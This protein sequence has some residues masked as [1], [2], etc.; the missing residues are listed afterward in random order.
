[1][2][3]ATALVLAQLHVLSLADAL[4]LAQANQP[5]MHQAKAS[6]AVGRA[7]A[8]QARAPLLPQLTGTATYQRSTGNYASSPGAVPASVAKSV[9]NSGATFNNF[10]FGLTLSQLVWDF[11]VAWENWRSALAKVESLASVEKDTWRQQAALVRSSF[12]AAQASRALV[13]VGRA[14][15]SA[16]AQHLQQ[17]EGFVRVGTQPE[18]ALY[19]ARA[20]L[21]NARYQLTN[22]ES[23]YGI[24]LAQLQQ[25]MGVDGPVDFDVSNENQP[26]IAG[27]DQPADELLAIAIKAR[28]DLASLDQQIRAQTLAV[29]AQWAAFAPSIGVSTGV[30][31]KGTDI[32]N[33]A[34]NWNFT[35]NLN[36]S[37][38]NGMLA[39]AQLKQQ[40]ANLI[41]LR[42]Q[43][44]AQKQQVRLDVA[45]ALLGI[46]AS[47]DG[48]VSA[49][50]AVSNSSQQ[51]RLAE[52]RFAAGV[53][54]I[55]ELSDA[56]LA[57]TTAGAQKVQAEFNLAAARVGLLKALG[58]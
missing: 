53:G 42:A 15:V 33:T 18:I 6:I 11:G 46:R 41:V 16:Q 57:A 47:R 44:D 29:R 50:D 36:W 51:L 23:N 17:T 31:D 2:M 22:A 56:Q 28:P 39:P 45:Q 1:M 32:T 49:Q 52:G 48:L 55:I 25:A 20:N 21:A 7:V 34:V 40:E 35:A 37:I 12:F 4:H 43:L 26:P 9:S 19:T 8:D 13:E 27:E 54:N 10:A 5:K 3:L 14:T 38:F 30:T 24:A 58:E